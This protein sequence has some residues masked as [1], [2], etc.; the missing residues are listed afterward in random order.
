MIVDREWYWR[1]QFYAFER[2]LRFASRDDDASVD[3]PLDTCDALARTLLR[4]VGALSL[5]VVGTVSICGGA[6]GWCRIDYG[7]ITLGFPEGR[8]R[9]WCVLHEVAHVLAAGDGHGVIFQAVALALWRRYAA[10]DQA[11]LD[12][13][14][15]AYGIAGDWFD[16]EAA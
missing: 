10:F 3:W 16:E 13:L 11:A 12:V 15:V 2:A 4:D 8:R 5:R 9:A 14:S 1:E 6:G 7:H